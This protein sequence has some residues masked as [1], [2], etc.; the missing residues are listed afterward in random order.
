MPIRNYPIGLACV[1]FILA[2]MTPLAPAKSANGTVMVPAASWSDSETRSDLMKSAA[3]FFD[4]NES[5]F[6][7]KRTEL[8]AGSTPAQQAAAEAEAAHVSMQFRHVLGGIPYPEITLIHGQKLYA[9]CEP[10]DCVGRKV[11]MVTDTSSTATLAAGFLGP[12]CGT[13][14][15][16]IPNGCESTPTLTIFYA[17]RKSRNPVLTAD[18]VEWARQKLSDDHKTSDV[19]VVERFVH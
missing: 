4:V 17:S 9:A 15:H 16:P 12:R 14:E 6:A 19:S 1:A 7:N 8:P 13:T 3:D 10:H 11:F 5:R 18:I 2:A